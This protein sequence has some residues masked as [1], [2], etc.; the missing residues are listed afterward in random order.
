[1]IVSLF[2]CHRWQCECWQHVTLG[3]RRVC[4][5]LHA[6]I[7]I[8]FAPVCFVELNQKELATAPWERS[9]I[10]KCRV[11]D[12]GGSV[13]AGRR[14]YCVAVVFQ[15]PVASGDV[16]AAGASDKPPNF[17][18]RTPSFIQDCRLRY[19]KILGEFSFR[20]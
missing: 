14:R 5:G 17:L 18:V 19:G 8:D 1:M 10:S 3:S 16:A 12:G 11:A 13:P 20:K 2:L 4:E 9:W 6:G 15:K 7:E